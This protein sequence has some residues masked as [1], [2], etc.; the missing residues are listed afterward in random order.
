MHQEREHIHA[1]VA[2]L[3]EQTKDFRP[4][5]AM[6]MG[7]GMGLLAEYVDAQ[8]IIPYQQIPHFPIST[9][10]GHEGKL[11]LGFLGGK[12]VVLMQGR[13]HFYEGHPMARLGFPVRVMQQLGAATLVLTNAAGGVNPDF[14]VGDLM[15]IKDHLNLSF[16]NPLL[17][18]LPPAG[19]PTFVDTFRLYS[20]ALRTLAQEVADGIGLSLREGVYQFMTG[21]SYE[22]PAEVRMARFLGADAIGMSTFPEALAARQLGMQVLG[23]SY[24]SN[25]AAG[26]SPDALSHQEVLETL[27]EIRSTFVRFMLDLIAR[28]P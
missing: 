15:L 13:V 11:H 1:A 25:L 6:V 23:I 4:E 26:I 20:P 3:H 2:F 17:G 19:T 24:I 7:S 16:Q 10:P 21:P 9:V 18:T 28:L 14:Q 22:T 5:V 8:V 27:E 12:R